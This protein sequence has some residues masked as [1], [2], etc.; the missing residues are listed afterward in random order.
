M[1]LFDYLGCCHDEKCAIYS[2]PLCGLCLYYNII[3]IKC[4]LKSRIESSN[5]VTNKI[6]PLVTHHRIYI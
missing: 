4:L 1:D 5:A 2:M 6:R 3:T